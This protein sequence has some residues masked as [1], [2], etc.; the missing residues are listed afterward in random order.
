MTDSTLD[1]TSPGEG[2][3]RA[4]DGNW[5]PPQSH[6]SAA[7][8]P[9]PASA[10]NGLAVAALVLGIVGLF[11]GFIP[12]TFFLA[13]I[14]GVLAL[15]FG[16]IGRRRPARKAMATW[17]A[18]LGLAAIAMGVVG[19][20]VLDQAIDDLDDVFGFPDCTELV[21]G[22]RVPGR[23]IDDFGDL[24]LSCEL[25]DTI[26]IGIQTNCWD[27]DRELAF[28]DYGYAFTDDLI[29]RTGDRPDC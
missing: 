11:F 24:S 20:V 21:D 6:P 16:L 14:L 18:V 2:W 4:S 26:T 19:V 5:Y 12:L 9:P 1:D 27:S 22:E 10:G 15:V 8:P 23:F 28:S 29:F 7:P 3:W 17:G 13:W 25:G